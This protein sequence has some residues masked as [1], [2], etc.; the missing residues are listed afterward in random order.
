MEGGEE[1]EEMEGEEM[2]E[3][4][5]ESEGETPTPTR[6]RVVVAR[7]VFPGDGLTDSRSPALG[8]LVRD[9]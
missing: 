6:G 9:R 5:G 1:E 7:Y 8:L 4:E 2:E 3:E